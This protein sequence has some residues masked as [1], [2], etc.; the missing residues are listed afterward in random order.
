MQGRPNREKLTAV[1]RLLAS[2]GILL[3]MIA[4]LRA[5]LSPPQLPAQ[6]MPAP[7]AAETADGSGSAYPPR[8]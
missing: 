4:F 2:I 8:Y 7:S 5:C 3:V 6:R 1:F